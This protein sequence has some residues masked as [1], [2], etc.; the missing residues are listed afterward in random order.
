V[1]RQ[2]RGLPGS[3][4]IELIAPAASPAEAA[5][6]VAALEQ[7]IAE[8]SARAAPETGLDLWRRTAILEGV[9]RGQAGDDVD[10]WINT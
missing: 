8:T 4:R 5:A 1:T 3:R 2:H 10:P 6:I 7:F 9:D